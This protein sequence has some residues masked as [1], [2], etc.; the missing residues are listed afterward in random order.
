M[1]KLEL[2][3]L[4]VKAGYFKNIYDTTNCGI[5]E[6]NEIYFE[7]NYIEGHRVKRCQFDDI[8]YIVVE[9]NYSDSYFVV[10]IDYDIEKKLQSHH[11][12]GYDYDES[13]EEAQ[14]MYLEEIKRYEREILN[15]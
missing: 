4:L 9:K 7:G 8:S 1:T 10:H 5:R 13:C 11:Y 2:S 12:F 15:K 14:E 6:T 3:C